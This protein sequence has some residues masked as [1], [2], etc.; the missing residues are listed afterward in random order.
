M[1]NESD[2]MIVYHNPRCS[3]SRCALDFLN[4]KGEAFEVVEYLKNTPTK[5]ELKRLVSMLKISPKDLI[6]KGES[7][8]KENFKHVKMTDDQW[9]DA[10]VQFPQLIERPIVIKN[11]KGVI[12]RPVERIAEIL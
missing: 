4:E 1:I 10:M 7:I 3:K 9:I 8:Y 11:N 2:K 6:R 12:A 5:T